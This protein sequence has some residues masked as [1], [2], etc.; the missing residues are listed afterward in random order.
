M[1][2]FKITRNVQFSRAA[3][4]DWMRGFTYRPSLGVLGLGICTMKQQQLQEAAAALSR[5]QHE[6]SRS[7]T[8]PRAISQYAP[9]FGIRC[10]ELLAQLHR[11]LRFA[12]TCSTTE[13]NARGKAQAEA[14]RKQTSSQFFLAKMVIA[15]QKIYKTMRSHSCHESYKLLKRN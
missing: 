3:V 5:C 2:S 7:I 8:G 14:P 13:S 6:R 12:T 11:F 4:W 1:S 9:C 15:T 10:R